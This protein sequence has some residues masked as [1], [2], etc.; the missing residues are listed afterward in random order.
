MDKIKSTIEGVCVTPLKQIFHPKGDIFHA[1]KKSDNGFKAFGE[2]YFSTIN[3]GEI[4]AWKLH[5]S[6][7]LNLVCI[8]GKIKFVLF[9]KRQESKTKDVF[10]EI[11]LSVEDNYAR[12]TIPPGVWMGMQAI[13]KNKSMLLNI[14]DIEHDPIEQTNT[15]IEQS[16]IQYDWNR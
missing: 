16:D 3:E 15:P 1:M 11:V 12:L 5:R 14:A 13:G 9:D 7:T 4:K 2:A 6:M 8:Q 10:D